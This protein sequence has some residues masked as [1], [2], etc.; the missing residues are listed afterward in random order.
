MVSE[1]PWFRNISYLTR[2]LLDRLCLHNTPC[3]LFVRRILKEHL[4]LL[5]IF[6]TQTGRSL[7]LQY[8][9]TL[10]SFENNICEESSDLLSDTMCFIMQLR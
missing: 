9:H 6:W 10:S 3:R 2:F 8:L 5:H 7:G 4:V 1:K